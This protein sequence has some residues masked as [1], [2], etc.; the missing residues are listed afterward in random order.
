[1]DSLIHER[2]MQ[3]ST[4]NNAE[5][6]PVGAVWNYIRQNHPG[7][8]LYQADESHPSVAGSYIAACC[9]YTPLFRKDPRLVSFNSSLSLAEASTIKDAVKLVVYDSLVKWNIGIYDSI[10][11][12]ACASANLNVNSERQN[13]NLQMFPNPVTDILTL[14]VYPEKDSVQIQI[15]DWSGVLIREIEGAGTRR[16]DIRELANGV[17]FIRLKN[18]SNTALKFVK[19]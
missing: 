7:I 18:R 13:S 10:N 3:I 12:V 11:S 1:M 6:S 2:Y 17:Y 15:Y 5:V 19:N 9:F 4:N 16:I 14:K 8:G